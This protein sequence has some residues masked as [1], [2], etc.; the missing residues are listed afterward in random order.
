MTKK[1]RDHRTWTNKEIEEDSEGYLAAQVAFAED[2]DAA[3]RQRREADDLARFAEAFVN[4][5]GSKNEA[6]AAYK[7]M[8]NDEAERGARL[9]DEEARQQ[10]LST[11]KAAI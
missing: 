6:G 7:V 5:G 2:R 10:H 1:P 11:T 9:A 4:A 3:E 8:R